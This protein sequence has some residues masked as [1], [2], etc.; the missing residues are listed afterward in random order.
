MPTIDAYKPNRVN[1]QPLSDNAVRGPDA[2]AFGADVGQAISRLGQSV[3]QVSDVAQQ[4]ADQQAETRAREADIALSTHIREETLG[5]NGINKLQGQAYVDSA[6]AYIKRIEDKGREIADKTTNAL[7]KQMVNRIVAQRLDGARAQI[8][9]QSIREGQF[10]NKAAAMARQSNQIT[11]AAMNYGDPKAYAF[12]RAQLDASI[13]DAAQAT[14]TTDPASLQAMHRDAYGKIHIYAVQDMI[15][16]GD[17]GGAQRWLDDA[18]TKG[19]VDPSVAEQLQERLEKAV[20]E[21]EIGYLAEG[22]PP[23]SVVSGTLNKATP[24]IIAAIRYQESRGN[25]LAVSPKGASGVMQVMPGTGPEAARLAG[26]SWEPGRM[27]SAAPADVKYQAQLGEAYFNQ[28]LKTFGGSVVVALAAYNAGPK[29]AAAWVAK[30]GDPA[31]GEITPTAWANLI[32]IAETKDYVAKITAKLGGTIGAPL[33]QNVRNIADVETWAK[34]FDD[35]QKR[36]AA[37]AAGMAVVNRNRSAE[38]QRQSDAWDAV[39]PYIQADTPWTSIPKNVWQGLDPQHQTA[40]MEAQKRGVNRVT[41]PEALDTLYNLVEQNP[42]QFKS[43]DVLRLAP[44]F[45]PSDFEQIRRMQHEARTNQ[46]EWK[47]PVAQYAQITHNAPTVAPP[48]LLTPKN[49]L[50]LANF[51]SQWWQAVQVKQAGQKE[52][53]TD[54][55]VNEIG[56]RLTAEVATGGMFHKTRPVYEFTRDGKGKLEGYEDIPPAEQSKVFRFL[57]ARGKPPTQGEVLETWRTLKATGDL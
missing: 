23:P 33:P 11:N 19:E 2:N 24:E 52:P 40:L 9:G 5:E 14:G 30:F 6:P 28:Q 38:N 4:I 51:K 48:S 20:T 17:T 43:M 26:V 12:E 35:P 32:P 22:S 47:K 37:R 13:S 44:D 45:S 50:A 36:N 15:R 34:Q 8:M 53:L 16:K 1:L 21:N 29:R 54:D 49:K 27:R 57:S 42:A 7:E 18:M 41:S 10:A 56:T 31:K 25:G 55:E 39:Q 3:G 46:G